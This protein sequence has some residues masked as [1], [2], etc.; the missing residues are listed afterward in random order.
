MHMM[1]SVTTEPELPD[2]LVFDT[3]ATVTPAT[4]LLRAA[5]NDIVVPVSQGKSFAA[6]GLG[7]GFAH[8]SQP[9]ANFT[10]GVGC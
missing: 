10:S 4:R 1:Y 2:G 3:Y 7:I 8:S 9:C 5:I 6:T